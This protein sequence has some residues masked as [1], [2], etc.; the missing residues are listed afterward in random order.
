MQPKQP[1]ATHSRSSLDVGTHV[2]GMTSIGVSDPSRSRRTTI[3]AM[4]SS[5]SNPG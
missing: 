3:L 1:A 2:F 5:P 4:Y